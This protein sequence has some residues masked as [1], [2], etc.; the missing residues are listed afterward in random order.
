MIVARVAVVSFGSVL[1]QSHAIVREAQPS[2]WS[3]HARGQGQPPPHLQIH[4]IQLP[5]SSSPP[6]T[7]LVLVSMGDDV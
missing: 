3:S 4:Y 7:V 6:L 5:T 2:K 1:D